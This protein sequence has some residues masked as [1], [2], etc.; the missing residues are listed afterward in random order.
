MASFRYVAAAL[1]P[2][3]FAA[4]AEHFDPATACLAFAAIGVAGV[5]C[6]VGL[7]ACLKRVQNEVEQTAL[8]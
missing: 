5:A 6:F 4:L 3:A 2:F 1:S 8:L 7:G